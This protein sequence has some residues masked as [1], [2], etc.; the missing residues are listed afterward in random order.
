MAKGAAELRALSADPGTVTLP[1]ESVQV[2]YSTDEAST[3]ESVR[4]NLPLAR[5]AATVPDAARGWPLLILA[6]GFALTETLAIPMTW[7][8]APGQR[9]PACPPIRAGSC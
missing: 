7:P 6:R 5:F 4:I 2:T 1:A 8:S 9:R 3:S